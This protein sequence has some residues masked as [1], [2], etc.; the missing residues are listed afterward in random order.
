MDRWQD[1]A[2]VRGPPRLSNSAAAVIKARLHNNVRENEKE[3]GTCQSGRLNS[4]L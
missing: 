3:D 4:G 1:V 2:E